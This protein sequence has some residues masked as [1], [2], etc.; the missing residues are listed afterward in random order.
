ML[1]IRDVGDR[2][3]LEMGEARVLVA[4]FIHNGQS[5][6]WLQKALRHSIRVY[7]KG[8]EQRI[9]DFMK[10]IWKTE[11]LMNVRAATAGEGVTHG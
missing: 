9:R 2:E 1:E 3:V 11:F 7:G 8:S 5:K 10:I 4:G 6:E